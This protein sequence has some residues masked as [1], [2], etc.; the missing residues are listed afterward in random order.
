MPHMG[1]F[2]GVLFMDTR[3]AVD[4]PSTYQRIQRIELIWSA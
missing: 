3:Y 2:T 1:Y 4:T